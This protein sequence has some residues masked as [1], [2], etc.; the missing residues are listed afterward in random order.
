MADRYAY[1]PYIGLFIIIAWGLGGAASD[2]ATLL[3]FVPAIAALCLVVAMA[4]A[5]TH[6]LQYWQDGVKLLTQA[7]IVAGHPDSIIEKTLA[8]SMSFAGRNDEAFL[9]YRE[10]C[11][12]RPYDP[13]CHFNMAKLL[14]NR[15]QQPQEALKQYQIAG[16][17][18]KSK[19]MELTC[20]TNS[21]EIL[22]DIGDY[23]TAE[24]RL[25]AALQLDPNNNDALML[26]QRL[27]DRSSGENR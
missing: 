17:Y 16:T 25:A 18:A 5:T 14:F 8:D 4:A 13:V 22:L 1:I 10:A 9:H 12:L 26:R 24:M 6:Y 19:D 2:A 3:R 15:H 20:L 7:S 11:V 21:A 23:Q 27:I